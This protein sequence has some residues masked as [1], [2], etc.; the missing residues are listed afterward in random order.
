MGTVE[1]ATKAA[2]YGLS[3]KEGRAMLEGVTLAYCSLEGFLPLGTWI[4]AIFSD[5]CQVL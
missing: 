4:P 1:T 2:P 3:Q 5:T